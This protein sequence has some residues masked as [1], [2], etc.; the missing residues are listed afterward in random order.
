M[1]FLYLYSRCK[2]RNFMSYLKMLIGLIRVKLYLIVN[3]WMLMLLDILQ[4]Y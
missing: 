1:Q 4:F 2:D 3:C